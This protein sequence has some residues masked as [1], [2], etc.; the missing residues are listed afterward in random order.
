M[1]KALDIALIVSVPF[2]S[3]WATFVSMFFVAYGASENVDWFSISIAEGPLGYQILIP[4]GLL[5]FSFYLLVW[6][7]TPK[8]RYRE[9]LI[10]FAKSR[11]VTACIGLVI[12][13]GFYGGAYGF[14]TGNS[15]I[16]LSVIFI[17]GMG[18]G[19]FAMLPVLTIEVFLYAA[20]LADIGKISALKS[21]VISVVLLIALPVL[22]VFGV[23]LIGGG[24]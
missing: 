7:V 11:L 14:V 18:L 16:I 2:L 8:E 15:P 6:A 21:F 12:P 1:K 5:C 17:V 22:I 23:G 20:V 3:A 19:I 24:L 4:T 13:V 9:G 10:N